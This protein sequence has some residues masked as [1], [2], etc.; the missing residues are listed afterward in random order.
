MAPQAN[1]S[2]KSAEE[3]SDGVIDPEKFRR[4][5]YAQIPT[6]GND[7]ALVGLQ[8][9]EA[10]QVE[11]SRPEAVHPRR[12]RIQL[13]NAFVL[14]GFFWAAVARAPN[15]YRQDLRRRPEDPGGAES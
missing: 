13:N 6:S 12:T 9:R 1:S 11:T 14:I 8:G 3:V 15:P 5:S 10:P 4:I 2:P 7:L